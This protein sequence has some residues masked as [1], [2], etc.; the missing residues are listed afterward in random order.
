MVLVNG[1]S[2]TDRIYG[3]A[4]Q[5]ESVAVADQLSYT[6][7]S[8][9][10]VRR[11]RGPCALQMRGGDVEHIPVPRG[12]SRIPRR[13]GRRRRAGADVRPSKW[14]FALRKSGTTCESRLSC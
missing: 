6:V 8:S 11:F 14:F 3:H 9:L 4:E 7:A 2:R 13:C 5:R 1:S 12:P 10:G